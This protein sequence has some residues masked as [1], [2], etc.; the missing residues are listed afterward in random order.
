VTITLASTSVEPIE[1]KITTDVDPTASTV[2]AIYLA[3]GT[4]AP[5]PGVGSWVN[6]TWKTTAANSTGTR[7]TTPAWFTV[8]GLTAGTTYDVWVTIDG[9]TYDPV[10]RAATLKI[11]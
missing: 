5:T 8:S 9:T 1:V 6:G 4:A 7:Y 11:I 10:M 2:K 3:A